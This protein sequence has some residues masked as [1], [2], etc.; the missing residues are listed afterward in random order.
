MKKHKDDFHEQ[1]SNKVYEALE[2]ES[3]L[4]TIN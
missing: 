3:F 1:L 2:K 4:I